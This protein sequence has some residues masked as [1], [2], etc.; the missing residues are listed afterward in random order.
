MR[1]W[2]YGAE[3]QDRYVSLR[4]MAVQYKTETLEQ[5]SQGLSARIQGRK[6]YGK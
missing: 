5:S 3:M 2:H 1:T 4:Q 6:V